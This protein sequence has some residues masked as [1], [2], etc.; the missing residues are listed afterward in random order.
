MPLPASL[1]ASATL[2]HL[3]ALDIK[4]PDAAKFLQ[5]QTSAQV[6][7]ADGRFAPLT[8]FCTPKG[9]MLA[10]ALMMKVG[11]DHLRLVLSRTLAEPLVQHLKKF[12]AF[13]KTELSIE[14]GIALVGVMGSDVSAITSELALSAL[15][16]W[17]QHSID[18]E[19]FAVALPGERLL[20]CLPIDDLAATTL[21]TDAAAWQLADIEAGLA[22]LESEQ[23][24]QFLPQMFNWEALGGVSFKKG[25]Y[26]GQE[27]VARAHFRGQVKKRLARARL[28]RDEM[29]ALDSS[30][31]DAN[32]K[33]V[34]NVVAAAKNTEGTVDLLAVMSTKAIEANEAL[35]LEGAAVTLR[36]LPYAIERRD[37]ELIA[38][39]IKE[40]T[41]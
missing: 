28:D 29:P 17:E 12:A 22:W 36:P 37:P 6:N 3:A 13:Y 11:D 18:D 10:N 2:D 5:G 20:L 35:A 30:V 1:N 24:D 31:T 25:C 41:A 40:R 14:N 7:L 4:G 15:A 26:T 27:V 39:A 32:D 34:G 23:S 19:R 9:R 21:G 33:S 8:C 38:A 16:D